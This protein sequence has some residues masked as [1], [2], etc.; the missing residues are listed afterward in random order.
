MASNK[1]Y[2]KIIVDTLINKQEESNKILRKLIDAEM[3]GEKFT[4]NTQKTMN[5][6]H[7]VIDELESTI[8]SSTKTA[9]M[10]SNNLGAEEAFT[11]ELS[12]GIS[13]I[14]RTDES[15][16][17][18]FSK[19]SDEDKR[20][21]LQ[22]IKDD[23]L[24]NLNL[25][26]Q[27]L[28]DNK[29]ILESVMINIDT[30]MDK[31]IDKSTSLFYPIV[32]GFT[33]T[34]DGWRHSMVEDNK[35]LGAVLS[36]AM[37]EHYKTGIKEVG[38]HFKTHMS[39]IM[40]PIDAIAGPVIAIGKS[41]FTMGKILLSG[42]SR[43]EKET[44]KVQ[45]EI[46]NSLVGVRKEEK[47]RWIVE[48]KF[49][50]REWFANK[51]EQG[52]SF[53]QK[54][55]PILA[56]SV[57]VLIGYFQQLGQ[58]IPS[59]TSG[60]MSIFGTGGKLSKIGIYFKNFLRVLTKGPLGKLFMGIGKLFGKLFMPLKMIWNFFKDFDQL[61]E[62]FKVGDISGIFN[63][64]LA[65]I[66]EP[67]LD[68]PEMIVN[69][70]SWLFG[71]DFRVD[72]GKTAIMDAMD[73]IIKWIYDKVVGPI[74]D[75][76]DMVGGFFGKISSW[77]MGKEVKPPKSQAGQKIKINQA[78]R[79]IEINRGSSQDFKRKNISKTLSTTGV[80]T[81]KAL[82]S[83]EH[84]AAI[85]TTSNKLD[86]TNK[87]LLENT[88]IQNKVAENINNINISFPEEIPTEPENMGV[89]LYNK[90]WGGA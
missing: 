90:S 1:E 15:K 44:A 58:I 33:R 32:E 30:N 55:I 48:Q 22:Q 26:N 5:K 52:M 78:G 64:L 76:V 56:L 34:L 27:Y 65:S 88:V 59:I 23:A 61:K 89:L 87:S 62:M 17:L 85:N 38:Q 25:S 20:F 40:A 13:N 11:R 18:A 31:I 57:G 77:F 60:L 49:R 29:D 71:S 86:Q 81:S 2:T 70:L 7:N 37:I 35:V 75:L 21:M 67:F 50:I 36:D 14:F 41:M 69:G 83:N 74:W 39:A 80:S 19:A 53:L 9:E 79:K 12:Y 6:L 8:I 51:K 4:I 42:P 46:R 54:L 24:R 73:M 3:S 84:L 45:R 16:R 63:N 82:Q 43:H 68:I 72:F 28:K 66:L 47:K 10:I